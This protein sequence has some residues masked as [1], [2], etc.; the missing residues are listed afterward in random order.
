MSGTIKNQKNILDKLSIEKLNAMQEAAH[1]AIHSNSD[2]GIDE[3]DWVVSS[4]DTDDIDTGA[5][6][7]QNFPVLSTATTTG[8]QITITGTFNSTA[9]S[10]FRIEFFSNTAADG[11]GYGEGQTYLGFANVAT[12]GSGNATINATLTA[13]VADGAVISATATESDISYTS[14]TNTSEF[15]QNISAIYVAPNDALWF[16]T[17]NNVTASGTPGLS[18]WGEDDIVQVFGPNLALGDTTDGTFSVAVSFNEFASDGA[19]DIDAI[20]YVSQD[21]TVGSST[22]VNLQAG[23]L[24]LST[25][26]DETLGGLAVSQN[27]L[28]GF[29]PDVA[30]DYS[31]GTFFFVLN[32]TNDDEVDIKDVA[33]V[34]SDITIG[35]ID[36]LAG[37]ILFTSLT[38]TNGDVDV[39]RATNAGSSTAT[40]STFKLV[41]GSDISI[42]APIRGLEIVQYDTTIGGVSLTAGTLLASIDAADTSV[43]SN[44]IS[45]EGH[46]VFIL[47]ISQA[48]TTTSATATML[49][50]GSDVGLDTTNELP[51]PIALVSVNNSAPTNITLSQATSVTISNP[52]FESQTLADG[53]NVTS[54]TGWTGT[55]SITG[56]WNVD[57]PS[58]SDEATEGQNVAYI[59]TDAS[60]GTLS[61]VLTET[62][63][64]DR[65]YTLSAM[66]GDESLA[67]DS[68]GWEMRLFAGAQLLGSVSNGDFDPVDG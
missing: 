62:F 32:R 18:S 56:V 36:L 16:A 68:S 35:G 52:G 47:D 7:G 20:H 31:S 6:E 14:F 37:D 61:Q 11:S 45:V 46:D 57:S 65:S 27:D 1:F 26:H 63:E 53:D 58:Y 38:V 42:T 17:I 43:G 22:P 59:N 8:T 66:V 64:A 10:Y 24:L 39:F 44:S 21:V 5:N 55:A 41:D 13:V 51:Y 48:G 49:F 40:G 67:G 2:M 34:E 50:D 3:G 25:N 54:I 15:A 30:G 60:G 29:R 12:D 9:N 33:L 19:V 4:N 23:D 28:V